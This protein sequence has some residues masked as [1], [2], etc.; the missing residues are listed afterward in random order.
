MPGPND[1]IGNVLLRGTGREAKVGSIGVVGL[2]GAGPRPVIM[3]VLKE[4]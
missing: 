3:D 2:G 4:M 1:R